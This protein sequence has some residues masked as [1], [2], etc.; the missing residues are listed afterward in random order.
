MALVWKDERYATGIQEVDDQHREMFGMVNGLLSALESGESG[1]EISA[2]LDLLEEHAVRHF[3]CEEGHME[4]VQCP[5]RVTNECAHE[6]FLRDFAALREAFEK[7]GNGPR[8]I[9]EVEEKVCGWLQKH[10]MAIDLVLRRF[11]E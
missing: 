7:H 3:A 8:F 1:R 6:C 4:R 9:S 11:A 2:R 5:V 10:L